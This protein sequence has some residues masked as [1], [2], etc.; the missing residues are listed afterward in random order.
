M[1][2]RPIISGVSHILRGGIGP[3]DF[4]ERGVWQG[5]REGIVGGLTV[6]LVCLVRDIYGDILPGWRVEDVE[7]LH[8]ARVLKE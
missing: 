1:L 7:G 3:V 5:L 6:G 4:N 2:V 8:Y